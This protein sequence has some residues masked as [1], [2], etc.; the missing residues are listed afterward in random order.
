[1]AEPL[2]FFYSFAS[3]KGKLL[4]H[5]NPQIN[6]LLYVLLLIATPFLLLQ[7]Y[8]QSAIGRFSNSTFSLGSHEVPV[9]ILV[10]ALII[11]L[12]L[13]FLSKKINRIR[14]VSWLTVVVF[15]W[16]G[17]KS[18]DFYF[19]HKY[20]ELQYNWHYF[21]YAI[22]AFINYSAM[23]TKGASAQKVIR[24]TFLLALSVSTLDELLQV[25]LSNRI[26]DVGDISKDLWGTMIG[27]FVVYFIFENGNILKNA[28]KVAHPNIKSYFNNPLS[29]LIHFFVVSYIFMVVASL[30][31]ETQYIFATILI[32]GCI[33]S[34]FFLIFHLS[35][36]KKA[37]TAL[38]VIAGVF[39]T[40]QGFFV[41]K[42]H[43]DQ[44]TYNKHILVYNGIP[45]PYFD[46]MI[47]P[48]GVVRLVDK[49][50]VFNQRDQQTIFN[51][52]E[53]IIIVGT[54]KNGKGGEGFPLTDETQ[55]IFHEESMRGKQVIL[56]K[57][58]EAVATYNRIRSEGKRPTFIYHN[59]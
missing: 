38:F 39:I 10:A 49:K 51:L 56:Q 24:V 52:S 7:N 33:Y 23:Q 9:V 1:M 25:P 3:M 54:G 19:N 31:T 43:N 30:L 15:L 26:F 44:I 55:F 21:A 22:F 40:I 46:V 4:L 5:G 53:N 13:I 8:L 2:S 20:Y 16:I 6:R 45:I 11:L 58:D 28:Q 41:V 27:L 47:R 18:T 42:Y 32:T 50:T 36:K 29:L 17:Q 14:L 35:Q 59:N 37:R 48:N 57:N 12:A 34:V